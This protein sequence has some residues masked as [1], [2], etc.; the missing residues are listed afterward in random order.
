MNAEIEETREYDEI[1]QEFLTAMEVVP[2]DES[3]ALYGRLIVEESKEVREALAHLLKELCDLNYVIHG[4]VNLGGDMEEVQALM[5]PNVS[6][7]LATA[8]LDAFPEEVE[9]IAFIRVHQSN[10][11]KLDDNGKPIRR[12]DGKVIKGPNYKPAEL[13]DLVS[14]PEVMN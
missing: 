4:F 7:E 10:M 9:R 1:Q 14:G 5:E 11:S 6:I 13:E 8:A 2:S 3:R 12:E